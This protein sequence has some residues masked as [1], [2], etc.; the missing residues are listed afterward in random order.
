MEL[1]GFLFRLGYN[2]EAIRHRNPMRETSSPI[3]Q[4]RGPGRR[5]PFYLWIWPAPNDFG[6]RGV[7][8]R[9]GLRG[10]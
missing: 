5:S 8:F 2:R 7:F 10:D 3:G 9:K 6:H 1:A 4:E